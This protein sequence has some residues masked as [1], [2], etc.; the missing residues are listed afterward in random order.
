LKY[1]T[2][3][4]WILLFCALGE[5]L[6]AVI[7]FP[8]PAAIYGL[9]L[10]LL[11]LS[12]KIIKVEQVADAAHYLISVMGVFFVSPVVN[13]LAYW[14]VIAPNLGAICVIF[15]TTT[16]LVFAVSGLVTR[17]LLPKEAPNE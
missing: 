6:Q 2:Q 13:I 4:F 5:L 14:G 15:V 12:L 3:F 16:A 17:A 10:L 7:P 11:A 1:L 9:V 8:I